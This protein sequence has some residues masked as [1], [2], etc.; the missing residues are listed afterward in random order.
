[1]RELTLATVAAVIIRISLSWG[2][3]NGTED[4]TRIYRE[5]AGTFQQVGQVGANATTFSETFSAVEGSQQCY[6]VQPFNASQTAPLSNEWCGQ[7]PAAP[8]P[9]TPCRTKGKSG[10]CR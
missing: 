3:P 8:P 10:K 1:M 6:M 7:V 4:G 9:P 2:D 5:I